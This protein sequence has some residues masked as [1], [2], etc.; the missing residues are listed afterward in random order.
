MKRVK[1]E[2]DPKDGVTG[3]KVMSLVDVPAMQSDF[4]AMSVEKPQYVE[5]KIEGYKQIV[6]GLAL[7]P[8]KDFLRNTP[9]GEQYAAYFTKESIENIRNKFH[10]EQMTSNVNVDHSQHDFI[11][12]YLIESFIIDSPDRLADV[13]AKGIKDGVIG[14]WFVAYKIEDEKTFKMVLDGKLKGFS[15]EI[16]VHKMF[17]AVQPDALEEIKKRI[18]KLEKE[19]GTITIK[20]EDLVRALTLHREKKDEP[21]P[22]SKYERRLQLINSKLKSI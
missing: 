12:A 21:K 6:A 16:F 22:K 18:E 10:K 14:A 3:V 4:V 19:A 7:I 13:T 20:G 11:D 8:D 1:F 5:M 2:I 17:K 15:V 9:E